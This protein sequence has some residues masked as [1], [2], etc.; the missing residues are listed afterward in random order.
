MRAGLFLHLLG[1]VSINML[2]EGGGREALF[3]IPTF[4]VNIFDSYI[5]F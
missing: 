1:A 3:M 2:L 4:A 5:C